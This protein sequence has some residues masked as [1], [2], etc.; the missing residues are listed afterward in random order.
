VAAASSASASK[1]NGYRELAPAATASPSFVI[2]N[3]PT[4]SL[5]THGRDPRSTCTKKT[6]STVHC[7]GSYKLT[8]GTILFSGTISNS[9]N[10][11][12]LTIT[13]GTGSY[14]GARGTVLTE[15]NA[16]E[17]KAKETITFT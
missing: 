5:H 11:N 6:S 14:K 4:Y 9:S 3:N 13:G 2:H 17:T 10:T 15:Y 1:R 16:G 12:R 8:H 7:T